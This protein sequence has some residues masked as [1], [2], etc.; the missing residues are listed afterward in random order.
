MR[1]RRLDKNHDYTFGQGRSDYLVDLDAVGQAIETRLRLFTQEWWE[2]QADGIPMF[3]SFLGASCSINK[4]RD[5]LVQERILGT[6]LN[7]TP[8]VTGI[9]DFFSAF[10]SITNAYA[11]QVIVDT[12]YGK[13][14]ASNKSAYDQLRGQ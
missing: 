1:Y 13:L 14:G 8:L 5:K 3:E 7:G 11:V 2:D 12:I 9:A 6:N 4:M 10:D